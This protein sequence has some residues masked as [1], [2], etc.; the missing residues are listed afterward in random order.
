MRRTFLS[1]LALLACGGLTAG[2]PTDSSL[3]NEIR[4]GDRVLVL[5]YGPWLENMT[6]IDAGPG[7]VVVDTWSS[8]SAAAEARNR[9]VEVFQKPV[10]LVINTHHH[11]DHTFGNQA[12]ADV[13]IM[14][15]R[16]DPVDM[17]N[18]YGD[19][20]R[21]RKSIGAALATNPHESIRKYIRGVIEETDT[22]L[23]LTPPNRLVDDRM[24]LQFGD[25]AVRFYHV[26]G[27]HARTNLTVF[28]PDLGLLFTRRE[29]DGKTLPVL[30]TGVDLAKLT[31]SME[32]IRR[33][34]MPVRYLIPG[35]GQYVE[36]PDLS[37]PL[38]YLLSLGDA[39]KKA[40]RSGKNVDTMD[41]RGGFEAFP[42]VASAQNVHEKNIRILWDALE[43]Q[44]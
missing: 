11:W 26:P 22:D 23:R 31:E 2:M 10:A 5:Q 16:F 33:S 44:P 19:L 20:D 14:G 15:H 36:D 6:A 28:V 30:E 25:L 32:D 34:N 18:E 35:H 40:M 29:F 43:L 37:I 24:V 8:P 4:V 39:V 1:C 21:R 42:Q 13:E 41:V 27:L 17:Q 3:F 7:L 12:F 38:A 9:I